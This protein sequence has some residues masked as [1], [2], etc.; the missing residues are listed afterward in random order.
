MSDCPVW[1]SEGIAMYF[2]TP[3]L[4]GKKE[5]WS[6]IGVVNRVRLERFQ[7]YLARRPPDSLQTLIAS[8]KRLHEVKQSLD[9]YAEAWAL[10]YFLIR[11]HPKEYISYLRM[12]SQKKPL[13]RDSPETR[14]KEFQEA[15]G[16][17]KKLDTEFLRYMNRV[18]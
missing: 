9:A 14:L 17:I 3:D 7:D 16:G 12:L 5:G 13:L 11:Q 4:N 15:F 18:R 2:E 6:G 1:F 8:D 10:T